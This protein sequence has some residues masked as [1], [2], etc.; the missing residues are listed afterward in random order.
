MKTITILFVFLIAGCAATINPSASGGSRADG[1]V[2]FSYSLGILR[3][4]EI[5]W[6]RVDSQAA[7]RC[8]AWD[9]ANAER[10]E[11]TNRE[12]LSTDSSGNC[13]SYRYTVTYQCTGSL[14]Q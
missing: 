6:N 14:D 12:C 2:E 4:A 3:R 1:I 7:R 8:E 13:S 10:F 9:Y 11:G 5:D